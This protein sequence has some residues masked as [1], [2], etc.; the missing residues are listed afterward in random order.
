MILGV[1]GMCGRFTVNYTYDQML[2]YLEKEYSIF[3]MELDFEL[4]RY[5]V[6]PGQQV[7]SVINDGE[8]YRV[9]T[10]KWGF[11]PEYTTDD[12]SAYK[13]INARSEDITSKMAF[14]DSFFNKRCII[15]SD[16]FYEWDKVTG[17]KNPYYIAFKDKS[18]VAFAGIWSRYVKNGVPIYT[19]SIL[20]TKANALV[21]EIH[22]RMPVVLS[23]I[24]AKKWLDNRLVDKDVLQSLL[25]SYD[26]QHMSKHQVSTHVNKVAND[27]VTCI[28]EYVELRLF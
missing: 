26:S 25:V 8:N 2:K 1:I 15:L 12:S 22:D 11:I 27:D 21:G 9:G 3:D 24:E 28:E 14:R 7:L 23:S 4:P 16:G 13:M 18:L 6:S 10:F 19:T 20:T 5:N 17:S